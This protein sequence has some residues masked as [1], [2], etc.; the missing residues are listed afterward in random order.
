VVARLAEIET[1]AICGQGKRRPLVD[2]RFTVANLAEE[3]ASQH[4]CNMVDDAMLRGQGLTRWYRE[5]HRDRLE[6]FPTYR[7]LYHRCQA[8]MAK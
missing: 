1:K 7:D 3:F 5:R 2:A 8:E 4:S 6:N